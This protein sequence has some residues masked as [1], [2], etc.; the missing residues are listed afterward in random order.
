MKRTTLICFSL[1][2]ICLAS[3]LYG[4]GQDS[5]ENASEH[6]SG[7][8]QSKEVPE[9]YH[10]VVFDTDGGSQV[11]SQVVKHGEKVSKP[12]D[13][14]KEWHIFLKWTYKGE[15]WSFL[16]YTVTEDMVLLANWKRESDVYKVN[17]DC[18]GPGEG[19][20]TGDGFYRS[21]DDAFVIAEPNV[22]SFF[23]GW[24]HKGRKLY[25]GL[26]YAV[27]NH[28]YGDIDIS[29]R[30]LEMSQAGQAFSSKTPLSLG[31]GSLYYGLYPQTHVNDPDTIASLNLMDAPEANG[32]YLLNGKYYAKEE[33][34]VSFDSWIYKR[35]GY[36]GDG[37][38]VDVETDHTVETDG[39]LYHY[40]TREPAWFLCEPIEW[41]ILSS[42][43]DEALLVSEYILDE[44]TIYRTAHDEDGNTVFDEEGN[45]VIIDIDGNPTTRNYKDSLIR[46]WLNTTFF[47]SAFSL[48]NSSVLATTVDNSA[49]SAGQ[50]DNQ[51]ACE[52][53]QDKV[54]LLSNVEWD[55]YHD[56]IVSAVT[57][58]GRA[59]SL[60]VG[61][62]GSGGHFTRSVGSNGYLYFSSPEG[63][64]YTSGQVLVGVRPAIRVR[65][66]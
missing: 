52:D 29:A 41:R 57:D 46:E 62:L 18:D 50:S 9:G 8:V 28:R 55:I 34:P 40:A 42:E 21:N 11:E 1:S 25:S 14:T 60:T 53:T 3:S 39:G 7:T 58:W 16:G 47:D 36:Y 30:F 27:K 5:N 43:G 17:L 37:T 4:C 51:H 15:D 6:A 65:I 59:H 22:G 66:H 33:W 49:A 64:L 23:Q 63:K 13:P 48:G 24:Y 45:P 10:L 12:E 54:F 44:Q 2:A 61:E 26:R 20:A 35:E 19:K 32:W 31:N 38:P 56:S